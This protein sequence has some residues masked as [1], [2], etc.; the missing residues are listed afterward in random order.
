[1]TETSNDDEPT[2]DVIVTRYHVARLPLGSGARAFRR[3]QFNLGSTEFG[4]DWSDGRGV[5]SIGN[6]RDVPQ[7][8]PWVRL[9]TAS[10]CARRCIVRRSLQIAR[11]RVRN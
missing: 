11:D 2:I 9:A 3:D 10:H 6:A 5:I 1:M 7:R 4:A 8:S